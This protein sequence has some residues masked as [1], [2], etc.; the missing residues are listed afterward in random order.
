MLTFRALA[1]ARGTTNL[2]NL[3]TVV[4]CLILNFRVS[5]PHCYGVIVIAETN[6]FSSSLFNWC[7]VE[8]VG[9]FSS[10]ESDESWGWTGNIACARYSCYHQA[11]AS[12][13]RACTA[14]T[15]ARVRCS[16][17]AFVPSTSLDWS[18]W[19]VC[20]RDRIVCLL[21]FAS[22]AAWRCNSKQ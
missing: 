8:D 14:L 15:S 3:F 7:Y 4:S 9:L 11:P 1:L 19:N 12:P 2:F 6:L 10:T 18:S 16:V 17:C 22:N 20:H 5:L 13:T 21:S